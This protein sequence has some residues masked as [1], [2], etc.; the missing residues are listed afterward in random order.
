MNTTYIRKKLMDKNGNY[1][2]TPSLADM[3]YHNDGETVEQ[4]ISNL[5]TYITYEMFGAKGDGIY[6]DGLAI[7]SA[8]EYANEYNLEIIVNS[9]KTYYI[10][11]VTDIPIKTNVNFGQAKFIIDDRDGNETS[12]LFHVQSNHQ[13]TVLD[14]NLSNI[15]TLTKSI[16]SLSGYG[17]SLVILENTNKFQ[18]IRK[19][20]NANTGTTQCDYNII[21]NVGNLSTDI[22]WDFDIV[23]KITIY[24]IDEKP[25][26][27]QGGQ[28]KTLS[29]IGLSDRSYCERG[30]YISRSNVIVQNVYH[31]IEDDECG[32]PYNG[33]IH[34]KNCVNLTVR[35]CV[36][37]PHKTF[38]TTDGADAGSYDIRLDG[39]VN[40]V[41]DNVHAFSFDETKW[42][43]HTSNF[44]KNM[45]IQN[46][47]M[48]R[49][50]AHQGVYNLTIKNCVLG[51]QGIQVIGQGKLIVED[52]EIIGAD[53]FIT[54][55]T[56]YGC[57]WNGDIIIKRCKYN[58]KKSNSFPSVIRA[59]NNG[60][61]DFG[62]TCRMAKS[63][64]IEDLVIDDTSKLD[65]SSYNRCPLIFTHA[66][67]LGDITSDVYKYPYFYPSSLSFKNIS[68]VSNT[69]CTL[70]YSGI[71]CIYMEDEYEYKSYNE[72][73]LS[74]KTIDIKPNMTINVEN[75]QLMNVSP[76]NTEYSISHIAYMSSYEGVDDNF[77]D[78]K[79]RCVPEIVFK[80]CK[81]LCAS[82][83]SYPC[84]LIIR[85][86]TINRLITHN[87]GSRSRV[88]VENS[89]FK[90]YLPKNDT[91]AVYTML[92]ETKYINC[93][94]EQ[95]I[96][97]GTGITNNADLE[98]NYYFLSFMKVLDNSY[99]WARSYMT[100]CSLFDKCMY[101]TTYK[102]ADCN[103]KFGN[104][105]FE[106]YIS[107]S[108]Y[109][110]HLPN[111][112]TITIPVGHNYYVT[113]EQKLMYFNGT[114][115]VYYA[116]PQTN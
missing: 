39:T 28:F 69:G 73:D 44:C 32:R 74:L 57:M 116:T 30:I 101:F 110:G 66:N 109:K 40:I 9:S 71:D 49:V 33:F 17:N 23:N 6:D 47:R 82:A 3:V 56:D 88:L 50:D 1:V 61:H 38:K 13:S 19:G 98:R 62:Y 103:F 2:I 16:P 106:Y 113:S 48:N 111:P 52:T 92:R 29:H 59:V 64:I 90:P 85:D 20:A 72:E 67:F 79:H 12:K 43:V 114:E 104:H 95:P 75:V 24:P 89:I 27:I 100:S 87:E 7:K 42:G 31:T 8:H 86:C 54:L 96:C 65:N 70:F 5:S 94:F 99:V 84:S 46:C 60:T 105:S 18:F 102:Y 45:L 112:S 14:T 78:N 10:K 55:R 108:G 22:Q 68:T 91:I 58:V 80:N 35:D 11:N 107:T 76:S 81:N 37:S 36:L 115:F 26:L 15:N 25:L 83:G 63:I 21:D 41:L 51:H 93:R 97:N 53:F 77:L 34:S 4:K